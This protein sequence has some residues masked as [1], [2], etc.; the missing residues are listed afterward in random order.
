MKLH[1]QLAFFGK[2]RSE[3][4]SGSAC[5]ILLLKNSFKTGKHLTFHSLYKISLIPSLHISNNFVEIVLIQEIICKTCHHFT[6]QLLLLQLF[7]I[8]KVNM[9]YSQY[10]KYCEYH[11]PSLRK[12]IIF[13][14]I[15]W[16][17]C[18]T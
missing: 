13:I 16:K 3:S 4:R 9:Y 8:R 6:N 11:I 10:F 1:S 12:L 14:A 7:C 17:L 18:H 15:F 2:S 5:L